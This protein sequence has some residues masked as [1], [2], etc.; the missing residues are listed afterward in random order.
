M[1][2]TETGPDLLSGVELDMID[3]LK[4]LRH[5][6][7]VLHERVESLDTMKA[8]FAEA[9]Y[10]RVRTDYTA[11]LADIERQA[12]PLRE[13]ARAAYA[14][15]RGV[16]AEL[17]AAHEAVRL[18]RQEIDLR[19]K[20]G[21]FEKAEYERRVQ[22]IEAAL[23]ERTAAHERGQQLRERFLEV[24][25]SEDDLVAAPPSSTQEMPT[26]A[27]PL[28]PPPP[29]PT[30]A[31]SPPP[32]PPVPMPA[33]TAAEPPRPMATVAQ[34]Q[35]MQALSMP[36]PP[37]VPGAA[38][39]AGAGAGSN[40]T[41]ILRTARLVPQNIEAGRNAVPLPPRPVVL[42]SD[43][44]CDVRIG[45]PGVDARHAQI[46]VDSKG[47][48]LVDLGSKAGTRVNAEPVQQRMLRHEDVIQVGTAR[49]V[50]REG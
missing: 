15:L 42:G 31:A 35:I 6:A 18:D 50:F 41:M 44:G 32:P 37:Q 22:A 20:L 47:Y 24:F 23:Q 12:Q 45:G 19:H 40:G 10:R 34:T 14:Q 17:G 29:M 5:D 30:A 49:F 36:P 48:T 3:A 25:D 13:R 43:A 27:A 26:A 28:P 9:V 21:E 8:D 7:A 1:V 4:A 46:N 16:I 33:P 2:N 38:G 39:D 11:R